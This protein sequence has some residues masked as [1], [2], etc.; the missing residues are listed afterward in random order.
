[1]SLLDTIRRLLGK[2]KNSISRAV[3][4][5][6]V[7]SGDTLT[8]HTSKLGGTKI[9][10]DVFAVPGPTGNMDYNYSAKGYIVLYDE[11]RGGYRTFVWNNITKITDSK[12]VE[13]IVQ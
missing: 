3:M 2:K 1:M 4:K 12:G 11:T 13:Y 7:L 8:I 10:R 5:Q 6:M 9:R